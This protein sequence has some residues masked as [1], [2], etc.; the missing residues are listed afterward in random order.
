[1]IVT[2]GEFQTPVQVDEPDSMTVPDAIG[3]LEMDFGEPLHE[4]EP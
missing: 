2:H 4:G 1:M 3:E